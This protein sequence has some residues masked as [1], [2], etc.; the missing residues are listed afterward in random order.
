MSMRCRRRPKLPTRLE[1]R[2]A[3]IETA[4][5]DGRKRVVIRAWAIALR[6][7]LEVTRGDLQLAVALAATMIFSD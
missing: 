3:A 6:E 1:H 2:P 4:V 5:P 7:A